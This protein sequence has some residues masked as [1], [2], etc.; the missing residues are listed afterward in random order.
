MG[1]LGASG[2]ALVVLVAVV[3]LVAPAVLV[4][5]AVVDLVVQIFL[6]PRAQIEGATYHQGSIWY[7]RAFTR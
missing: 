4:L 6:A 3:Q 5:A 2:W 7:A 1:R